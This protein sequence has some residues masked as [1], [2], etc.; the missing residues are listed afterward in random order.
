MQPN[1]INR[2]EELDF[3]SGK[4]KESGPQMIVIYG[5]RRVGKT[6]L[7]ARFCNEKPHIFFLANKRGTKANAARLAES[8][9]ASFSDIK[10]AANDFDEVFRYIAKRAGKKR[11][12]V[13]IDEFSYL[14]EQDSAIPSVF[15][16]IADEILKETNIMLILCGSSISM[17]EEGALSYKSPLYGRRTGQWK[18]SPLHIRDAAKFFPGISTERFV[19]LYSIAGNIPA[20][21]IK[22]N[23]KKSPMENIKANI[24]TKGEFLYDE[25][26]NVL[27][28]ELK[29]PDTY[30]DILRAMTKAGKPGEISSLAGIGANDL[31]KYVKTLHRL[32]L[33]E[34][35]SMVTQKK[36]KKSMYAIKDNFIRFW[37]EFV[38]PNRS[39]LEEGKSDYVLGIIREKFSQMVGK[40]FEGFCLSLIKESAVK[41]PFVPEQ[42]GKE[43]GKFNGEPGKNTYE[44]DIVALNSK[45]GEILFGECK[46]KDKVDAAKSLAELKK[47]AEMVEW[48]KGKRKEHYCL[49]AKSFKRRIQE[50]GVLLFDLKDIGKCLKS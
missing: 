14:I 13:V 8:S 19:E 46:W 43:W 44:I 36:P 16:L 3:L 27:R 5:R 31:P 10:P 11:F 41:L 1:F 26:E 42:A 22:L 2:K 25:G 32:D 29:E 39:E 40:T 33:V 17:M 9:A 49:F 35:Y 15:Q 45:T 47:K 28:Q 37:F 50:P 4:W 34:K 6:A 48:N 12:A 38:W 24:L 23:R 18:V 30:F 20:Y 21:L 7:I